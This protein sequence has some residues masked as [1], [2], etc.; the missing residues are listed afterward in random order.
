MAVLVNIALKTSNFVYDLMNYLIDIQK[1]SIW[2]NL[3]Q[4]YTIGKLYIIKVKFVY[5]WINQTLDIPRET[6]YTRIIYTNF[7]RLI[8]VKLFIETGYRFSIQP[9]TP[10]I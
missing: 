5:F 6:F 9:P 1:Y 10:Q 4:L 7:S 8:K 3:V 2:F